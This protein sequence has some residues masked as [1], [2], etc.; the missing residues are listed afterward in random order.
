MFLN[1][2]FVFNTRATVLTILWLIGLLVINAQ[3]VRAFDPDRLRPTLMLTVSS[4]HINA[5]HDFNETNPGFSLG[6][7]YALGKGKTEIGAE[8]G[9][10]RNSFRD[11][12][13]FAH[14]TLTREVF[15]PTRNLAIRAGLVAGFATYRHTR[16]VFARN[17]APTTG[18]CVWFAGVLA[19]ARIEDRYE[20]RSR[21]I[22]A[23]GEVDGLA[24]FEFG[25]LF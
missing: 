9:H 23:G 8:V 11:S 15:R 6:A 2:V 25:F 4:W 19:S 14:V 10:Y 13:D 1:G 7:V 17:G 18:N 12:S 3:S 21:L 5:T 22:P 24:T 20:F 16:Q